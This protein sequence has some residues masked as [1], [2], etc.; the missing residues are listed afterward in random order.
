M[1]TSML[2]L[3][4]VTVLPLVCTPGPD[5]LFVISQA[6]TGG[7]LGSLRANAGVICGYAAH[8][9][10]GAMGVAA[11]VAASPV[12][13]EALRWVGIAYLA[14]LALQMFRSAT[15]PSAPSPRAAK[16]QA[17]LLK[18]FLTSFLNPKGLLVYFAILP[19]FMNPQGSVAVQA[20]CLSAVFIALCALVYGGVGAFVAVM[21]RKGSSNDTARRAGEALAGGMLVFAAVRMSLR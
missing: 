20:L 16:S 2:L 6:L 12:L 5:I 19:N 14:Y 7:H 18:G 10:L 1:D 21:G 11:L 3:F 15:K 17:S 8:A 4:A 9:V 13:F